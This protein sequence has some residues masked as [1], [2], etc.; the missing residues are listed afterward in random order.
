M[1]STHEKHRYGAIWVIFGTRQPSHPVWM[2]S[3]SR[4]VPGARALGVQNSIDDG[5]LAILFFRTLKI[6]I[7]SSA[8]HFILQKTS[9]YR[10]DIR[11]IW[12]LMFTDGGGL[13]IHE[14]STHACVGPIVSLHYVLH[15]V[16]E[17]NHLCFHINYWVLLALSLSPR[18]S[19]SYYVFSTKTKKENSND[20]SPKIVVE[21]LINPDQLPI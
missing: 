6:E 17:V 15:F 2:P 9:L 8:Q 16:C 21:A 3:I 14:M 10:V 13:S 11:H 19:K 7:N 5:G 4:G 12:Y 1:M 20:M 18:Y